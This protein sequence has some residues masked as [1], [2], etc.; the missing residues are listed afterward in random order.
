M[1]KES[2]RTFR[3][4]RIGKF[5]FIPVIGISLF[6]IQWV[7]V[8]IHNFAIGTNQGAVTNFNS[9]QGI[10]SWTGN[11]NI[12]SYYNY[13]AM[14]GNDDRTLIEPNKLSPKVAVNDA[15]I[16]IS[17]YAPGKRKINGQPIS[18]TFCPIFTPFGLINGL[19]RYVLNL[20]ICAPLLWKDILCRF[21]AD[22]LNNR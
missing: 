3:Y 10:N 19:S 13:S 9:F 2:N 11:P 8:R 20:N 7:Q 1:P 17:T 21:D 12:F 6:H 15:I 16:P 22:T 5:H 18:R 14:L 4:F